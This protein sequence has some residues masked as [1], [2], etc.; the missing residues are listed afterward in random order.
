MFIDGIDEVVAMRELDALQTIKHI[1]VISIIKMPAWDIY[2]KANGYQKEK[3]YM[4]LE[5][6]TGGDFFD[7]IVFMGRLDE[8]VARFYFK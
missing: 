5:L 4:V 3:L 2:I 1:N 7:Y 8:R 6:A